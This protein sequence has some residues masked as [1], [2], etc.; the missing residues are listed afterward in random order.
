MPVFGSRGDSLS[1][2]SG[3]FSLAAGLDNHMQVG[4]LV[5]KGRFLEIFEIFHGDSW[6]ESGSEE[7]SLM[8]VEESIFLLHE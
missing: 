6:H 8:T 7:R 2:T 1:H 5:M 4:E 3:P